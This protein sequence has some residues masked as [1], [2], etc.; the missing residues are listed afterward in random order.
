MEV[1]IDP[2]DIDDRQVRVN[3]STDSLESEASLEE[4][5]EFIEGVTVHDEFGIRGPQATKDAGGKVVCRVVCVKKDEQR[6]CVDQR[7]QWRYASS[8]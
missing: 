7:R 1:A 3:Q 8:R 6:G 5:D 2:G 4:G